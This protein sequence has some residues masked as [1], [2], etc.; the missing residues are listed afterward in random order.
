[1]E[2]FF[3]PTR[4]F[5]IDWESSCWVSLEGPFNYTEV[6]LTIPVEEFLKYDWDWGALLAFV[7]GDVLSKIIWITDDMSII[8]GGQDDHR[9]RRADAAMFTIR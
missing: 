9:R 5:Q 3:T 7:T 6:A 2:Q 1:M 8:V 4:R